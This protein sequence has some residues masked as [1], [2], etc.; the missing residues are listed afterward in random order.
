[1][2]GLDVDDLDPEA[3]GLLLEP[4]A[5]PLKLRVIAEGVPPQI[6]ADARHSFPFERGRTRACYVLVPVPLLVTGRVGDLE[7]PVPALEHGGTRVA[8]ECVGYPIRGVGQGCLS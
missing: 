8:D 7:Y 1:D 4:L 6:G 5:P 2:T 3:L